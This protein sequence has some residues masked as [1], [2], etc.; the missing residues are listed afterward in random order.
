MAAQ[1]RCPKI[2]FFGCEKGAS[3]TTNSKTADAPKDAT[4]KGCKLISFKNPRINR[5]K[6]LP[7]PANTMFLFFI[8]IALVLAITNKRLIRQY[9]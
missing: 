8:S 3:G 1:I 6:K 2:T 7:K 4:S 9:N 5:A